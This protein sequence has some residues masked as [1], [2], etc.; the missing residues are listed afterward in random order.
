MPRF[1]FL[2]RWL[3]FSEEK[4][5]SRGKHGGRETGWEAP[6]VTQAR[7]DQNQGAGGSAQKGERFWKWDLQELGAHWL[8]ETE[9]VRLGKEEQS[10]AG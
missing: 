7:A 3:W 8:R 5:Q 1:T 9:R 4:G 6:T 10:G 2:E